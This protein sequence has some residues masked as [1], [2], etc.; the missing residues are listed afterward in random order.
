MANDNSFNNWKKYVWAKYKTLKDRDAE[1][2]DW[3]SSVSF[4]KAFKCSVE[5]TIRMQHVEEKSERNTR[6]TPTGKSQLSLQ[7]N[8]RCFTALETN[9]AFA[10]IL[11]VIYK[12]THTDTHKCLFSPSITLKASVFSPRV[13]FLQMC[14][15]SANVEIQG[16]TK[17]NKSIFQ[18]ATKRLWSQ[19]NVACCL[20]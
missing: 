16:L 8:N 13:N 6:A 9:K 18:R 14:W 1:I 15:L 19:Q 4:V 12:A 10:S 20:L 3:I 7:N 2:F 5:W 11:H 17:T